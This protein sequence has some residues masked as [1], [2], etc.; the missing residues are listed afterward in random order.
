MTRTR[1]H[2]ISSTSEAKAVNPSRTRPTDRRRRGVGSRAASTGPSPLGG[3]GASGRATARAVTPSARLSS[4]VPHKLA[5]IPAY[6]MRTNPASAV[7][8]TAPRVFSPYKS[9]TARGSS[10]RSLAMNARVR[11]GRV[12]P[13]SVV[14]TRSTSAARPKRSAMLAPPPSWSAPA[15]PRYSRCTNARTKGE[16]APNAPMASSSHP[17]RA[18]GRGCRSTRRPNN[19]APSPRPPM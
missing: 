15:A 1:V 12:P 2:A 4:A 19:H 9:P 7:P 8:T 5:R 14:G 11:T 17:Y 6:S 3:R 18:A 13:M 10:P 16:T